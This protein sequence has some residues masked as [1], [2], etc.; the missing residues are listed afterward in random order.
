MPDPF[1][2]EEFAKKFD[3]SRETMNK[4]HAYAA[5]IRQ[6][7]QLHNLVSK[8]SELHLW[9]RH[10]WDSAQLVPLIGKNVKTLADLG[11]G[12]GFPGL[13]LALLLNGRVKVT[14]YEATGKKCMFLRA[15]AERM[16]LNVAIEQVRLE[17]AAARCFDVVTARALAPLP[18]LLGYAQKFVTPNTVCL[19]PK[20]RNV[21]LELTEAHKCWNMSLSQI[22]SLTDPS[23]MILEL[24]QVGPHV[25]KPEKTPRAGCRQS[26]GR[27]R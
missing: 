27:R 5:L 15:A 4:L 18:K 16:D 20:G 23:A 8:E 2:P 14:L 10:I 3:V 17:Q 7:N 26:K 9:H 24:R 12:A 21:A 19:F 13:I 6:W 22:P 11:S 25:L 1:G